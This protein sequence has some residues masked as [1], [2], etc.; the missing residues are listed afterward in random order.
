MERAQDAAMTG[1][2][3]LYGRSCLLMLPMENC[4]EF[5]ME[6]AMI[7][8]GCGE[9]PALP[10]LVR[11]Q[12][13]PVMPIRAPSSGVLMVILGG[14]LSSS[15]EWN[16]IASFRRRV[17]MASVP[18]TLTSNEGG[19]DWFQIGGWLSGQGRATD[20][21]EQILMAK[22]G[23]LGDIPERGSLWP[24]ALMGPSAICPAPSNAFESALRCRELPGEAGRA[25]HH[26]RLASER[27]GRQFFE[28][29]CAETG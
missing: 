22:V 23:N 8:T 27:L 10:R 24:A 19:H 21:L 12:Y 11:L 18:L 29:S 26:R 25:A 2:S 28:H 15:G 16:Q 1:K 7:C 4:D 17:F 20:I 6:I 3:S 5:A 13:Q 14:S 9:G